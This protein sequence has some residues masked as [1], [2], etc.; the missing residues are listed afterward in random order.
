MTLQKVLFE[1]TLLRS[2]LRVVH[3]W[4]SRRL[5][6]NLV[7][8]TA[9]IASVATLTV[10]DSLFR[11]HFSPVPWQPIVIYGVLANLCYTSGW[12]IENLAERW[13]KR[14]VYGLGPALFRYGLAFS[15]GL[16]LLPAGVMTAIGLVAGVLK[17]F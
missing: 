4:E 16:T 1:P 17:L 8:G 6:Y 11:G 2:P 3:W 15:V 7:V 10:V 12:M 5:F 13:L 14:P 9:G